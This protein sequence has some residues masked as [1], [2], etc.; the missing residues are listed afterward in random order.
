MSWKIRGWRLWFRTKKLDS[1]RVW[2]GQRAG[3][4]RF[5]VPKRLRGVRGL[6]NVTTKIFN[7]AGTP[8]MSKGLNL[9]RLIHMQI[10]HMWNPK[11]KM[12][13]QRF[14]CR[15]SQ[16][17]IQNTRWK[18]KW[19]SSNDNDSRE[20]APWIAVGPTSSRNLMITRG[21]SKWL[22]LQTRPDSIRWMSAL[23]L[24]KWVWQR[25]LWSMSRRPT[26]ELERSA[27]WKPI[28]RGKWRKLKWRR[29][30]R[31]WYPIWARRKS[32]PGWADPWRTCSRNQ[33]Q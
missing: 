5:W 33:N 18:Y 21:I 16:S 4:T 32:N 24:H 23:F 10:R 2:I 31:K 22:V 28:E 26:L 11:Q 14:R 9:Q 6:C 15:R 25:A 17:M 12:R 30:W 20:W 1:L 3:W 27:W 8:Q 7:R 29:G 13:I 19:N